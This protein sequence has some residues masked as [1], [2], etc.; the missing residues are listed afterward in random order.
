MACTSSPFLLRPVAGTW[1]YTI[2][3]FFAERGS[4]EVPIVHFAE[5][6]QS[7]AEVPPGT[8][9]KTERKDAMASGLLS[10]FRSVPEPPSLAPSL[11]LAT[12]GLWR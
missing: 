5:A 6:A 7:F 4:K 1:W 9:R 8:D 2:H 10:V 11:A 12:D 3:S